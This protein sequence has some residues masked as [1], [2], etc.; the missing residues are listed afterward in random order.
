MNKL[1][2]SSRLIAGRK[3]KMMMVLPLLVVPFL[4]MA[5]WALGGGRGSSGKVITTR[6]KG[7]NLQLPSANLKDDAMTDKMSFY[8]QADKD[9]IKL[10][11]EMRNDPYYRNQDSMQQAY[12]NELEQI[13]Q[14]SAE[15]FNQSSIIQNG[16]LKTSPYDKSGIPAEEKV[17]KKLAELNK[18]INQP[19]PEQLSKDTE[20][21]VQGNGDYSFGSDVN[22]L[23]NMMNLMNN[24]GAD[25]D[26]EMI[27]LENTLEKILDIQHPER[28]TERIKEKSLL[29]KEAVYPVSTIAR[30][31]SISLLDTGME[32]K[33][34]S[35]FFG[36]EDQQVL[37]E[38][39]N[40][41]EA[42]VHE[43]QTLVNG[44]VVKLRL[45]NDVYI[46]GALIP[47]GTF[48]FG[49]AALAGERLEVEIHSI[50]YNQSLYPVKLEVYDIDGLPG[51]Y[52]PGAITRDVAKQSAD[53]GLQL[54]ELTTL[55][56]SLKAQATA[57]GISAAKGL[58]SK[59]VKQVKVLVKA[60]YKVLLKDKNTER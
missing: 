60:G 30:K 28:V 51:I 46:N 49:M 7:L 15:K 19:D 26:P 14:Q 54:M 58:L 5:F 18:A 59:K 10:A 25:N 48:A 8:D 40:S 3:R 13:T 23:E 32:K 42:V 57:A 38:E 24:K 1:Q 2:R 56:P 36:L 21:Y 44:A 29:H 35:G 6:Q 11:E 9:S 52:I 12:N 53:N 20:E 45:L 47:K 41:I 31:E 22:R 16:G 43:T 33:S 4:T 55:D 39:S 27:Q 34:A 50:R 17:M 37:S